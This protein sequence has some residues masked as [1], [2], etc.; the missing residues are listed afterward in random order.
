MLIGFE[1]LLQPVDHCC[2]LWISLGGQAGWRFCSVIDSQ[3][4][5]SL[6]FFICSQNYHLHI[7][8]L[9]LLVFVYSR[10]EMNNIGC[11][12]LKMA[13]SLSIKC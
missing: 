8:S 9:A 11:L 12:I 2:K 13:W 5:D 4:L 7:T 10:A 3:A 1:M 6:V